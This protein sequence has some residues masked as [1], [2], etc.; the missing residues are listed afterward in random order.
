M[1]KTTKE[2]VAEM[3]DRYRKKGLKRVEVW[4]PEGDE[5]KIQDMAKE[6]RDERNGV[7]ALGASE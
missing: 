5:Q 3:R 2:R 1:V 4:V 7:L 6:L